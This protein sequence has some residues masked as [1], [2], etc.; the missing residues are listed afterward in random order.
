VLW[1]D[2]EDLAEE[3]VFHVNYLGEAL[4]FE[5]SRGG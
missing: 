1:R 4:S 3:L 5:A 2:A